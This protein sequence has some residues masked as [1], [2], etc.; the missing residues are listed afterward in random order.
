MRKHRVYCKYVS[1][2]NAKFQIDE[3]QSRH[4]IKALRLKKGHVV[5]VFDGD[6]KSASCQ[7]IELSKKFITVKRVEEL[8]YDTPPKRLL[9]TI[10][11]VI[12]K[13]NFNFMIQKL[14]EIGTNKFI[15]YKP[16]LIDQS[17]AKIDIAK[18]IN[19][20]FEILIN[21]S[22]QCGNNFIPL[23]VK[24]D[25]LE[26]A[27][28]MEKNTSDMYSFDT[29]AS[30]YFDPNV[31][32]ENSSVTIITGSESGFSDD[33]LKLMQIHNIKERYLG[34]NILRAET[35]PIYISSLIKNHFGKII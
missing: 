30:E 21:V 2:P 14:A 25:S 8:K 10:V 6:G 34:Q 3:S 16:D 5:E 11:P 23:V 12:K 26:E 13:S 19:K 33:E 22:K 15:I 9:V 29:E 32:K 20:S 17:V 7:I 28:I 27:I 4:L 18:M 24:S 1:G 35:A 31:L